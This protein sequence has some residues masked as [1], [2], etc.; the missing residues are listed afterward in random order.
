MN[1][2]KISYYEIEGLFDKKQARTIIVGK[3][4]WSHLVKDNC[5]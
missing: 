2:K 4:N 1:E 5:L 3:K